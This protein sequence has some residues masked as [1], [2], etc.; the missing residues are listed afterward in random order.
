MR[1]AKL[2]NAAIYD[3]RMILARGVDEI[4]LNPS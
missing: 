1:S 4:I 3:S 2:P